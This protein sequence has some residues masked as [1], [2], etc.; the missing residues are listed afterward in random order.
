MYEWQCEATLTREKWRKAF[1]T[2]SKKE[3]K[4]MKKHP[5]DYSAIVILEPAM[6]LILPTNDINID[7]ERRSRIVNRDSPPR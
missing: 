2:L 4:E 6:P 3:M 7:F 1:N 5:N